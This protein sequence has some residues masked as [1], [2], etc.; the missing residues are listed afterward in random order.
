MRRFDLPSGFSMQRRC[1]ASNS[2][3]RDRLA[4]SA[5]ASL[6]AQAEIACVVKQRGLLR[7]A[8]GA[9]DGRIAAIWVDVAYCV[10]GVAGRGT[11]CID[12]VHTG[13]EGDVTAVGRDETTDVEIVRASIAVDEDLAE[14]A[15]AVVHSDL[16][17]VAADVGHCCTVSG[18]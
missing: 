8:A 4:R 10:S 18:A 1:G 6:Q 13:Q 9:P 14:Q 12:L 11:W 2:V 7:G 17:A 5:V 15:H 3:L 16:L